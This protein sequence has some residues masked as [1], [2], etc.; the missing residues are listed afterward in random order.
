MKPRIWSHHEVD[1]LW[2]R[3]LPLA[4]EGEWSPLIQSRPSRHSR[5]RWPGY[6]RVGSPQSSHLEILELP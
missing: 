2:N 6:K 1:R 5:Q 3:V 4:G